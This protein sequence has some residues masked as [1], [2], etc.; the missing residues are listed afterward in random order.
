MPT[1]HK[2]IFKRWDNDSLSWIEYYFKTS[3]DMIEETTNYKVLTGNERLAINNYLSTFNTAG[4]L[5]Q[6]NAS[7]AT[8]DPSKI[9]RG[10]IG[11]LSDTYLKKNNPTFT[12]ELTGPSAYLDSTFTALDGDFMVAAA[13]QSV[14]IDGLG[15]TL[16]FSTTGAAFDK[17]LSVVTPTAGAH[18]TTKTYVDNLVATGL[19]YAVNGPVK[20]ATTENITLNGVQIIDGYNAVAGDRILVKNQ[21][22][23]SEN[24]IYTVVALNTWTKD[25]IDSKQG[26]LVFVENGSTYNDWTFQATEDT[27]WV[28]ASKVDSYFAGTGL[29]KTGTTFSIENGAITNAMLAGSIAWSKL[30]ATAVKDNADSSYDAWTD[31][32]DATVASALDVKL[33]NAL[34]AIGLLRG[35]ANYNTN[36]TQTIAGAYTIA[37]SKNKTYRGTDP[38]PTGSFVEGDLYFYELV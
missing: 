15:T 26:K 20:A 37:N 5:V 35:T 14:I 9:D 18:A 27:S 36:N 7:D 2:S 13:G 16:T 21:S 6:I 31:L 11:D 33:T 4:K 1:I 30:L 22:T 8:Q 12:G 34:A 17:V 25:T 3:A 10:L 38:T 29:T 32:G 23:A 24:G 19:K 28:E